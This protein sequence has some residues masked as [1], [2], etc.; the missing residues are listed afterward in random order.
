MTVDPAVTEHHADHDGKIWHFCS[1]S[2]RAKFAADPARYLAKADRPTPDE[3]VG[4]IWT[5]PMHPE[6]RRPEP[7]ACPICGMALEP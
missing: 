1:A 3:P 5:C 7:G 2:C 4:A 6:I